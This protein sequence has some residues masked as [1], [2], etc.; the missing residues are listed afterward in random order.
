MYFKTKRK[1]I[2]GDVKKKL[3]LVIDMIFTVAIF[4]SAFFCFNLLFNEKHRCLAARPGKFSNMRTKL[5][6]HY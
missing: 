5:T 6:D 4:K 1:N 2:Q 3:L